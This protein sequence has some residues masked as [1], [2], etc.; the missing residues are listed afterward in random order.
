MYSD[1]PDPILTTLG[2]L[3]TPLRRI[4]VLRRW[5]RFCSAVTDLYMHPSVSC[6]ALQCPK[7]FIQTSRLRS[8]SQALSLMEVGISGRWRTQPKLRASTS[9]PY[10]PTLPTSLSAFYRCTIRLSYCLALFAA[11]YS[12]NAMVS[13]TENMRVLSCYRGLYSIDKF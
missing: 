11:N 13:F 1:R 2:S 10:A 9:S 5:S 3:S 12:H 8:Y 7:L 4:Y 6:N